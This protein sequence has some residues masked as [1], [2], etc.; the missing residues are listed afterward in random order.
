LDVSAR[1][2]E[3]AKLFE[4]AAEELEQAVAHCRTAARHFRNRE[5]PR[6]GAHAWAAFG[7]ILSAEQALEEQARAHAHRSNP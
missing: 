7:H 1:L 3:A 4:T 5:V 2:E 6:G